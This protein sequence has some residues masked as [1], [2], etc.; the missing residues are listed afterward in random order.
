MTV[1]SPPACC[2]PKHTMTMSAI[3]MKMDWIRSVNETAIKPPITVYST[4]TMPPTIIA[5]WYSTPKR[6]LKSVPM[7]LK[8]DAVYGIKKM[9]I[10][11][12]AMQESRCFLSPKRRA[13]KSGIVMAPSLAE[14]RRRR[15]ATISQLRYVPMAR[16]MAVHVTSGS[17]QR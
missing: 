1:S 4:T 6:L 16:P 7:A 14:Y 15:R 2:T 3:V 11:T 12:A 10:T 17:P 13:K 9:R 8:P 5:V